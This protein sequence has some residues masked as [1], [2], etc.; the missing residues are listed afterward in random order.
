MALSEAAIL[1]VG[2]RFPFFISGRR[3]GAEG[4]GGISDE[5]GKILVRMSLMQILGTR[6]GER[7]MRR[8][9]GCRIHD[10]V[11]RPNDPVLDV[12]IEHYVR[13][14]IDRWEPRV[15][16]GPV[17][18]NRDRRSEGVL[19]IEVNYEIIKFATV[20]SLVFPWYI[21]PRDKVQYAQQE[22]IG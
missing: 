16:V 15:I 20:D 7:V 2:W 11:F 22:R 13:E 12:E 8:G 5:E 21:L 14:S 6:L 17:I 1:G 9:F 19:F 3:G 18:I 4:M 10:L